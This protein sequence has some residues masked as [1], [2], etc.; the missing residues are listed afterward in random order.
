MEGVAKYLKKYKRIC[1]LLGVGVVKSCS[2]RIPC[3]LCAKSETRAGL[4]S[5]SLSSSPSFLLPLPLPLPLPLFLSF[6]C[7]WKRVKEEFPCLCA[8]SCLLS[9]IV[10][11][12]KRRLSQARVQ[13]IR[14]LFLLIIMK[15]E[16]QTQT[17]TTQLR[18]RG[19]ACVFT[20]TC[21]TQPSNKQTRRRSRGK[22]KKRKKRE[23]ENKERKGNRREN[24]RPFCA[25]G[26]RERKGT[27]LC[28][29]TKKVNG[30]FRL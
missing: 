1:Q 12:P 14:I 3:L 23:K 27:W 10:G 8:H 17:Q 25:H 7:S 26:K 9:P 11:S 29:K 19:T 18:H 16:T 28:E 15:L 30:N 21:E 13:E 6:F 4:L 5:S 24:N 20:C 2:L 22:R